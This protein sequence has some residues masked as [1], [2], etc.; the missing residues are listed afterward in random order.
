M[1]AGI[2]GFSMPVYQVIQD[3]HV[4]PVCAQTLNRHTS[5]VARTACNKDRHSCPFATLLAE[6]LI[7]S[8]AA[9][10]KDCVYSIIPHRTS[11][12]SEDPRQIPR[13]VRIK[14]ELRKTDVHHSAQR[15][16]Q[17]KSEQSGN[18]PPSAKS[19]VAK[20]Y[21]IVQQKIER[22]RHKGGRDLRKREIYMTTVVEQ[23]QH[24][25]MNQQAKSTY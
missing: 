21:D 15:T 22:H 12:H 20:G 1:H 18:H 6:A 19:A 11:G 7:T 23:C 14:K 17:I 24:A 3:H 10:R 5:D 8:A 25:K 13:D 4:F 16:S 2:D 9:P